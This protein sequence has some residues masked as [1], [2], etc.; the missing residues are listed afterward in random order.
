MYL[1]ETRYEV[2]QWTHVAQNR[3]TVMNAVVNLRVL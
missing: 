3:A 2:M 1:K